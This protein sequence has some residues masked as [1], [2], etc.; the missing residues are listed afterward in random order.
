MPLTPGTRLGTYDILGAIGA[1]GMG[2]V[3][4]AR[5]TRLGREVAIKVLPESLTAGAGSPPAAGDDRLARF[6]RE[7]QVL[8]ALNHPNIAQVY[9]A[10]EGPNGAPYIVMELVDGLTLREVIDRTTDLAPHAQRQAQGALSSSKGGSDARQAVGVGPHGSQ[11]KDGGLPVAE[12]LKLARQIALALDAAHEKGIIHR[13]L[14]PA[15]IK[16]TDHGDVKVLDFGLA[17]MLDAGGGQGLASGQTALPTMTS[18]AM[19]GLGVILGTAAYM[20]PEQARG[21]VVDKRADIWAFGCVLY[22]MLTGRTAFDGE[23]ITDILG[24]IIHKDPDWSA[25]PP[26]LP[27]AV[28]QLLRR[29]LQKDV[30][31][32]QRDIGDALSVLDGAGSDT[33]PPAAFTPAGALSSVATPATSSTSAGRTGARSG[34]SPSIAAACAIVGAAAGAGLMWAMSDRPAP[35]SIP[36]ARFAVTLPD[37]ASPTGIAITPAGDTIVIEADRLYARRIDDTTLRPIPG[38]EG[39]RNVFLS[40]DGRWAGFMA[41]GALRKVALA[42]GDTLPIGPI[43]SDS[44]GAAWGAGQTILYSPGWNGPLHRISD[45]GGAA[46]PFTTID[47]ADGE[48]G[49]WW[50]DVLPGETHALFTIWRAGVGINDARIGVL[51]MATGRHR[52]LMPGAFPKFLAPDRLLYFHAG[53]YHLIGFDPRTQATTGESRK[54]LDDALPQ[55]PLGTRVKTVAASHTGTIVYLAGSLN[56]EHKLSW[57][58]AG[59]AVQELAFAPRAFGTIR[60]SPDGRTAAATR[61]DSGQY[62]LWLYD[63]PRGTEEDLAIAGS[64]FGPVWSPDGHS[65]AFVSMRAG[66]F[67]VYTVG[68]ADRVPKPLIDE[69]MDQ[70]PA[71]FVHDRKRMI[72]VEYTTDGLRV[73]VADLA[74][75]K[76]RHPLAIP[77]DELGAGALSKD[78]KWLAAETLRAGRP[79]ILVYGFPIPGAAVQVSRGGGVDPF[80]A[81]AAKVLYYR[82]NN[83]ILAVTYRDDRGRFEVDKE[84]RVATTPDFALYGVAP[85]GRFLI[86]RDVRS[87]RVDVQVLTGMR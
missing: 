32:R 51:D 63:L 77:A 59:G 64:A 58:S 22:E 84:E 68:L 1:G 13:D 69:P 29:C 57:L 56:G 67:D 55:D 65:L 73:S 62:G 74:T 24:A 66:H 21:K 41:G 45:A 17:K 18:P 38:T 76:V 11:K 49:H 53:S 46:A 71:A 2:E 4:R 42:G 35:A 60:L 25:L 81:P 30:R 26:D 10:G 3:Y 28:T 40:R 5:D 85:D 7:A 72:V 79:E 34:I 48:V 20:A 8:A 23:T 75:P 14:K 82:R 6:G 36:V 31:T 19:T 9:D 50:P 16:L 80:W 33:V 78:D 15:N 43:A 47:A 39:A 83:D 37:S 87:H 70:S 44:P 86:G 52:A 54:V 27:P 61:V 12:S